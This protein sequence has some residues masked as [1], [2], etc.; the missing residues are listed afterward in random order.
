MQV[1]TK[2]R[3][4]IPGETRGKGRPRMTKKGHA[5][6]DKNTV[7]YENYVKTCYTN[8]YPDMKLEGAIKAKVIIHVRPPKGTSKKKLELMH[9][10]VIRPTKKPDCDNIIKAILDSLN[11]IAFDDDKQVYMVA[12]KKIF[13]DVDKVIVELTTDGERSN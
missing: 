6:T 11:A 9:K 5:Y 10:G 2:V 4:E 12:A 13:S 7:M 8:T 1:I 3:F